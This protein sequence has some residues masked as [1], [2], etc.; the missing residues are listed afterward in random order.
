M[1]RPGPGRGRPPPPHI[2]PCCGADN[3]QI[4]RLLDYVESTPH[5]ADN[6]YIFLYGDNGPALFTGAQGSRQKLV[7]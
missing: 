1:T 2:R 4:G 3:V 6:T 5:L 7:S